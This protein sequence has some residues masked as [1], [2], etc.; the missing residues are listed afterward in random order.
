M[1]VVCRKDGNLNT[2]LT[3]CCSSEGYKNVYQV[4]FVHRSFESC[5]NAK[6]LSGSSLWVAVVELPHYKEELEIKQTN[7]KKLKN[8][9]I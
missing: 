5:N 1:M 7:K 8:T 4:C 9:F 6:T 3:R 2:S